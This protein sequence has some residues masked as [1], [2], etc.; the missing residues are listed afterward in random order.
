LSGPL[1]VATIGTTFNTA[2]VDKVVPP[3]KR[4]NKTPVYVSGVK[5]HAQIP[6]LDSREV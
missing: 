3:G 2:Q 4:R 1:S 5:K 6:G